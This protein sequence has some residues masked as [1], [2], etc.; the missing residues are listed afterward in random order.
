MSQREAIL[1]ICKAFAALTLVVTSSAVL[2]ES[3]SA[4]DTWIYQP[5]SVSWSID[6]T[7]PGQVNGRTGQWCPGYDVIHGTSPDAVCQNTE[8]HRY[9][10]CREAP[11]TLSGWYYDA[12][13]SRCRATRAPGNIGVFG[14]PVTSSLVCPTGWT[15]WLNAPGASPGYVCAQKQKTC[16]PAPGP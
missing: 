15:L 12:D 2:S 9:E 1:H 14:G 5:Y 3:I 7:L 4:Q 6:S 11:L 10:D 13:M 16:P 8:L